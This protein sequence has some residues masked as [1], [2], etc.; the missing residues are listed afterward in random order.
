MELL[1]AQ[2]RLVF[3]PCFPEFVPLDE[4]LVSCTLP[5]DPELR[6][7]TAAA[8]DVVTREWSEPADSFEKAVRVSGKLG[9]VAGVFAGAIICQEHQLLMRPNI[10]DCDLR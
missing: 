4:L 1:P 3:R 9:G 6:Y 8:G 7:E 10:R 2:K 5:L